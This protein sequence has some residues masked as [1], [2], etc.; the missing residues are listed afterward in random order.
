MR[1]YFL[2]LLAAAALAPLALAD[3]K[4]TLT[5]ANTT[6]QFVGSKINGKHEGGFKEVA[7]TAA[8]T[9]GDPATLK[10]EAEIDL[11]STYTD[12]PRLTAHL[13][14]PDF[15]GVKNNP[16]STFV[17][18]KVEKE[19]G[20]YR[21]TGD[22]T[23][24]GKTKSVTFPAQISAGPDGLTL[25]SVFSLNRQDFGVSYGKGIIK[26]DVAINL[27]IKAKP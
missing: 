6:I 15:F 11:N 5:G 10:I 22:L 13:K 14:S 25:T 7:G 2:G 8:L 20:G 12:A 26:D 18:T 21:V 17:S 24:N 23:L 19:G 3:T 1:P 9:G 4:F 27:S 16:K